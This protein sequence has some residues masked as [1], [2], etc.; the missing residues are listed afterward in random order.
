MYLCGHC[1]EGQLEMCEYFKEHFQKDGWWT[2]E[3][4]PM[5]KER[6]EEDGNT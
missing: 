6:E 4:C 5:F 3:S 2:V 1:E